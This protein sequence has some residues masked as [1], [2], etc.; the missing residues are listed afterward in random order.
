M[1]AF[2]GCLSKLS[3]QPAVMAF[4]NEGVKLVLPESS[5]A[6]YIKDIEKAGTMFEII[7]IGSTAA[8][9]VLLSSDG[10]EILSRRLMPSGWN[11]RQTADELL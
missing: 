8:K 6:N 4:M 3:H 7:D 1:K 10:K 11:S 9:A 2:L 5:A